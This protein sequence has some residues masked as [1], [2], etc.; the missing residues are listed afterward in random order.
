MT[1]RLATRVG[2]YVLRLR[3]VE[4]ADIGPRAVLYRS[5]LVDPLTREAP[6]WYVANAR[7]AQIPHHNPMRF[8]TADAAGLGHLLSAAVVDVAT[9]PVEA[10]RA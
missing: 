8:G 5:H 7:G 3:L 2:P 4:V 1:P 9:L 10:D 6:V